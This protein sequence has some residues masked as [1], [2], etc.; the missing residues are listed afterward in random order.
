ML[1]FCALIAECAIWE[2]LVIAVYYIVETRYL[3]WHLAVSVHVQGRMTS[4]MKMVTCNFKC[5]PVKKRVGKIFLLSSSFVFLIFFLLFFFL[6]FFVSLRGG[7]GVGV[8]CGNVNGG[9]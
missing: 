1:F 2:R 9:A 5:T 7:G 8:W 3:L 4:L 6:A